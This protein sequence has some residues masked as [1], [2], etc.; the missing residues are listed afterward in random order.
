MELVGNKFRSIILIQFEICREYKQIL[1]EKSLEI[2]KETKD[3]TI[4]FP[5]TQHI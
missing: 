2:N 1:E 3:Y 5:L 4:T